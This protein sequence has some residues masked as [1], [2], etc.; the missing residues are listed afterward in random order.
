MPFIGPS[1]TKITVFRYY[2]YFLG[3][4]HQNLIGQDNNKNVFI[5]SILQEKSFGKCQYRAILWMKEGPK[6]LRF[7][8]HWKSLT[9]KWYIN[10]YKI[11]FLFPNYVI[12]RLTKSTF[13]LFLIE[14]ALYKLR[15]VQFSF[16]NSC[17]NDLTVLYTMKYSKE[18]VIA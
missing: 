16:V 4:L 2:K 11:S 5:L 15:Y 12:D 14:C 13:F 9:L 17:R 1:K 6:W 3:K 18:K 8:S 10:Q 7:S